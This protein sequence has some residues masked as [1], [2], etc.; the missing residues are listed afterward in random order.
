MP[1][2]LTNYGENAALDAILSGTKY[3]ALHTA[4]PTEVGNVAELGAGIGYTRQAAT[5]AAAA[6]GATSNNGALNFGPASGAGYGTVSHVSIWDAA[7]SGNCLW[8]GPLTASRTIPAGDT[9]QI[10]AGDLDLAID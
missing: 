9:F 3:V 4:D 7:S 2:N 1:N 10:A 8:Y 5:F 6:G